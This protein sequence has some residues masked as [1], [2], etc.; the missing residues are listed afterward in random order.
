MVRSVPS[1]GM[2][3]RGFMRK[4]YTSLGPIRQFSR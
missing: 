4:W 2:A 1:L 3:C